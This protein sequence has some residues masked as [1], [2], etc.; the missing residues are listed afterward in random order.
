LCVVDHMNHPK[1]MLN[2]PCETKGDAEWFQKVLSAQMESPEIKPML[3]TPCEAEIVAEKWLQKV[4]SR[5]DA[6]RAAATKVPMLFNMPDE[7]TVILP[8]SARGTWRD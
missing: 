6:S 2:T 1:P 7:E 4:L 8:R 3:N 5:L